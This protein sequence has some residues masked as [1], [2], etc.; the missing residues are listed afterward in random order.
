MPKGL[1]A[2]LVRGMRFAPLPR[3]LRIGLCPQAATRL[4][5]GALKV[6]V[7]FIGAIVRVRPRH[8]SFH[9]LL[10]HVEPV[11]RNQPDDAPVLINGPAVD[12][13]IFS[14]HHLLQRIARLAAEVLVLFRCVDIGQAD[15]Y[16]LSVPV[17][18]QVG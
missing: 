5:G 18:L 12:L 8:A 13:H 1:R 7:G 11:N 17:P 2:G 14:A 9:L 10:T 15:F 6:D 16:F 3:C 4:P